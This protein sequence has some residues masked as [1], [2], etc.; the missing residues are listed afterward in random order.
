MLLLSHN[1]TSHT[2]KH[3]IFS[4]EHFFSA[5]TTT[6]HSGD[7]QQRSATIE[8]TDA[9]SV[10]FNISSTASGEQLLIIGIK[11]SRAHD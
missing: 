6:P 4:G 3:F 5:T 7:F 10:E 2:E 11:W 1:M 8:G 9:A